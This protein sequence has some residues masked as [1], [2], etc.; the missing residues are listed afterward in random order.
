MGKKKKQQQAISEL[1]NRV[2]SV[3]NGV[4]AHLVWGLITIFMAHVRE[5][6]HHVEGGAGHRVCGR[7]WEMADAW[8]EVVL[9]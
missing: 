3:H 6:V 5:A 2:V 9:S 7:G 1:M 8:R 4:A